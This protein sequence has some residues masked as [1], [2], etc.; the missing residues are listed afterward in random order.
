M[1]LKGGVRSGFQVA[2]L[3]G[4]S[5]FDSEGRRLEVSS[6][7]LRAILAYLLLEGGAAVSREILIGILWSERT[8]ANARQSLRQELVKM[9]AF[10]KEVGFE[11]FIIGREDI[12]LDTN[13]FQIDVVEIERSLLAGH[14]PENKITEARQPD[15]ILYGLETIDELF[16]PWVNRVRHY[17]HERLTNLLQNLLDEAEPELAR[18][19]ANMLIQIDPTHEPAHRRL[20]QYHADLGNDPAAERQFNLLWEQL[21][22]YDTEPDGQSQELG[23]LIKSGHYRRAEVPAPETQPL[24]QEPGRKHSGKPQLPRLFVRAFKS[25]STDVDAIAFATGLRL[26]FV[27]N[28]VRF[29][30]WMVLDADTPSDN[31]SYLNF[32]DGS[33]DT[34]GSYA[35]EGTIYE[36]FGERV[37]VIALKD[38]ST[39]A[40]LWSERVTVDA[41]SWLQAQRRVTIQLASSLDWHLSA[42]LA[43]SAIS[44]HPIESE[45]YFRWLDSHHKIWSF[46]P[47]V[48]AQLEDTLRDIIFEY[49]NFAPAFAALVVAIDTKHLIF[50]GEMPNRGRL[51]EG[52]KLASR[53][54]NLDPLDARNVVNHA[55]SS[56]MLGQFNQAEANFRQ[57]RD[58]NP[59]N[60]MSS[61]S[62]ANGLCMCGDLETGYKWSKESIEQLPVITPVQWGFL[63]S[64]FFL[65]G[66]YEECIAAAERA[67]Q[68]MPA[69]P[70]FL[71]AAKSRIGDNAGARMAAAQFVES[72]R[73]KW[74]GSVAPT[75]QAVGQWFLAHCP[76]SDRQIH[77]T[78]R[79]A[80]S[81]AGLHA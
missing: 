24:V 15:R 57:A 3:G 67:G 8:D 48:R 6:K 21:A 73:S 18:R 9:R 36:P 56:A 64:T 79:S 28:L 77:D 54:V 60:P 20:M 32:V 71:V 27:S 22:E 39:G 38:L 16:S 25:V 68:I 50:P 2:V 17:W 12:Y 75:P 58:L 23:A 13:F 65:C 10:F 62:S 61:I 72:C 63:A 70:G 41:E 35:I 76:I 42:K 29:R 1:D 7:K 11:N 66:Q 49:P 47:A 80:L 74:Q 78:L 52:A 33:E 34:G 4:F 14:V 44:M 40:Y 31:P 43:A 81:D 55:W 5:L 37:I 69:V 45:A 26:E 59:N 51:L 30:D 46:D 19:A 53:A